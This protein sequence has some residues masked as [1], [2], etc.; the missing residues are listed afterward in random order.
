VEIYKP[1]F[2]K[3]QAKKGGSGVDLRDR[4]GMC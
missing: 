2:L 3:L 4:E 1:G